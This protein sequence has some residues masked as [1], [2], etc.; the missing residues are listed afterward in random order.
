MTAF[1]KSLVELYDMNAVTA[2]PFSAVKVMTL[3]TARSIGVCVCVCVHV[4]I[5][6]SEYSDHGPSMSK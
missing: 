4:C 6:V 1:K 2:H 5:C 3:L